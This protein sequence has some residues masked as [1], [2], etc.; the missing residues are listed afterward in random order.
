MADINLFGAYECTADE[1]GRVMLPA[2]FKK[3]IASV[4]KKGFVIK[5]SIFS[6][7]LEMYPTASWNVLSN[8]V[9]QLNKFI[10]KNVEFI[11]LF[12][13]GVRPIELD[14][15]FR[16]HIP[17]DLID[18]AGIKK[19]VVLVGTQ[20]RIEVWDKRTYEKFI[21]ENG[22]RFEQLAQEVMGGATVRSN[23]N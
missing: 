9:N 13:Y 6:K 4:L 10:K 22:S 2:S 14:G 3:Q 12:N 11:R 20:D 8:Q 23:D 21:K 16:F 18:F 5:Q 15:T 1:K 7:S 17:K 19:D